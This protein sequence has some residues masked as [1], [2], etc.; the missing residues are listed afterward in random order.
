[1]L[2]NKDKIRK[3]QNEIQELL[4]AFCSVHLNDEYFELADKLLAKMLGKRQV[5]FEAGRVEIWA[6]AIIHA[7]GTINFMFDK[8]NSCHIPVGTIHDFF[9]TKSSTVNNRSSQICDMFKLYH[10]DDEFSTRE[11]YERNP[12]HRLAVLPSGVIVCI[13]D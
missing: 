5:P 6:A 8:A 13:P 4:R 7:L 3:R 9:G 1:M 12:F 2:T 11:M 10:F